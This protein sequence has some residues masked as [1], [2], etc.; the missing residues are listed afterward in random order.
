[1]GLPGGGVHFRWGGGIIFF[2]QFFKFKI[3]K[4]NETFIK[5]NQNI[6]SDA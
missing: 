1:M 2:E 4:Q 6:L 3:S 5:K